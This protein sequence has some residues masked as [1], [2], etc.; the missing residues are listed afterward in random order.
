VDVAVVGVALFSL[1][2]FVGVGAQTVV[3][4]TS[5]HGES[6]LLIPLVSYCLIAAFFFLLMPANEP[7]LFD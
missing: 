3:H 5:R 7:T 2:P 1:P 6:L 4:F